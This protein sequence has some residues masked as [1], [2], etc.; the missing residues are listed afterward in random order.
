[1]RGEH[2]QVVLSFEDEEKT[3]FERTAH[4]PATTF[5]KAYK[6]AMI[7]SSRSMTNERRRSEPARVFGQL[8][9]ASL[10]ELLQPQKVTLIKSIR[11][12]FSDGQQVTMDRLGRP[13]TKPRAL[14][15]MEEIDRQIGNP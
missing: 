1:M 8:V 11:A 12:S 14:A 15:E 7:S 4:E 9:W 13:I 10:D 6:K 5:I 3:I 2:L